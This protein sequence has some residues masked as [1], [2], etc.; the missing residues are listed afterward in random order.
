MQHVTLEW[1]VTLRKTAGQFQAYR[2]SAATG[3]PAPDRI[4][5]S[6]KV[7]TS[8]CR[9]R[10]TLLHEMCHFAVRR[11]DEKKEAHGPCFKK[12]CVFMLCS[13]CVVLIGLSTMIVKVFIMTVD[14]SGSKKT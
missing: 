3:R 12:W 4:K 6:V 2:A 9:L 10:N 1:S 5:L 14:S 13:C 8:A 7:L 11:L